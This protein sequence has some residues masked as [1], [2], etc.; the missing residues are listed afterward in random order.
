[1]RFFMLLFD[2]HLR[3]HEL[4]FI[5]HHTVAK[6]WTGRLL[7]RESAVVSSAL[8]LMKDILHARY[9]NGAW[10]IYG[11]Q[12]SDGDNWENDS[13][14]AGL[15]RRAHPALRSVFRLHRDH[16]EPQNLWREVRKARRRPPQL[17]DAAHR[18]PAGHLSGLPWNSL[19]RDSHEP[20]KPNA[21]SPSRPGEWTFELIDAY[22]AE[23]DRVARVRARHLPDQV[24]LI[25]SE[26][27][28]DAYSSVRMPVNYHHWSFGRASCR[29]KRLSPRPDGPRLRDRRNS[30]L[31]RLPHGR[32]H[33]DD[34]GLVIARGL[35]TTASSGATTCFPPVDQPRRDH[36]LP[37]LSPVT[38]SPM[39]G[40]TA[41]KKSRLLL[42]SPCPDERWRRPLYKRPAKL[43]LTKG[44]PASGNAPI[45]AKPGG[46]TSGVPCPRQP[47]PRRRARRFP[48]DPRRTCSTSSKKTPAP[49]TRQRGKLRIVRK[50]S[51]YLTPAANPGDERRL[52]HLLA[53]PCSAP[54]ATRPAH[55]QLHDGVP[56]LPRNV[57]LPA[58]L[59]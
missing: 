46:M 27:M 52:G 55:R 14:T 39:R 44:S 48:R 22:H 12:A 18:R 2:T 50:I 10:N 15:P 41:K 19:E 8:E 59:R 53:P 56:A 33:H 7:L 32:K 57:V 28:M 1:M 37:D 17:C 43:S 49:R 9:A 3:A 58:R 34:A 38:A 40:A 36:R 23:I 35:A 6:E 20:P 21:G 4:V 47:C 30:P 51:Q 24:E 25:T 13:P 16:C 31:H 29:P 5:R 54:S 42:D 11:A 26:Q 45:P